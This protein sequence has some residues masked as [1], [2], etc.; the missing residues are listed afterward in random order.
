MVKVSNDVSVHAELT[1]LGS[2]NIS[3][4]EDIKLQQKQI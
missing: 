3:K 1:Q 2:V 4:D